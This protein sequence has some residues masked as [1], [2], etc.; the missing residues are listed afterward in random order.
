M[1]T[2]TYS[3]DGRRH[4]EYLPSELVPHVA[5][6]AE[7]GAAYQAAVGEILAINAQLLTLW[8]EQQRE[9]R[10]GGAAGRAGR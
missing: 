7:R 9:G 3:V 10:G 6:F 5:G 8:R 4:V 2:L 1:W